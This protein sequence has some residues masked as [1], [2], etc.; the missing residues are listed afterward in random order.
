MVHLYDKKQSSD[1]AYI[2]QTDQNLREQDFSLICTDTE[3]IK[4][5]LAVYL[6]N[7]TMEQFEDFGGQ[8]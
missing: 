2:D 1:F 8:R 5:I 7:V 3:H 4:R 6:K